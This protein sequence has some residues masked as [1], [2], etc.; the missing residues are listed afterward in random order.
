MW[1]ENS[2][3]ISNVLDDILNCAIECEVDIKT[4]YSP[5][6]EEIVSCEK[7]YEKEVY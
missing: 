6:R 7:C 5:E 1:W 4:T 3:N 2:E